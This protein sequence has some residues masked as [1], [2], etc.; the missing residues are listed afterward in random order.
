MSHAAISTEFRTLDVY[1]QMMT[2]AVEPHDYLK[3]L[4]AKSWE[5]ETFDI[6][7]RY[8]T[9]EM[10]CIDL[11]AWIGVVSIYA[12]RLCKTV[13][14]L[15]PDPIAYRILGNNLSHNTG[16]IVHPYEMAIMGS[17]GKV[18]IGGS[19][20]G[21]SCTRSSCSLNAVTVYC[22]N[23]GMFA[24]AYCHSGKLFVKCDTEGSELEIFKDVEFFEKRKPD[25]LVSSHPNWWKEAGISVRQGF[26]TL[27]R[28]GKIY[29]HALDATNRTPLDFGIPWQHAFFTDND[30]PFAYGAGM[31]ARSGGLP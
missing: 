4:E 20:L 22:E 16:G 17:R 7:N 13:H 23:L 6:L 14:A 10:V 3:W 11:G 18:T 12:S 9:P 19:M 28:V 21:C 26:E 24:D 27:N 31:R 29:K 8:L 25:V 15:E 2:L 30:R 1:G 5:P